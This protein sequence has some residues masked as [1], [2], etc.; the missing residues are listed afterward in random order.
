MF[1]EMRIQFGNDV[2]AAVLV[3][4]PEAPGTEKTEE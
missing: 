2:F 3:S 1:E 4:T